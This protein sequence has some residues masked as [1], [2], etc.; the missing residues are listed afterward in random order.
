MEMDTVGPKTEKPS[1][2]PTIAICEA[3]DFIVI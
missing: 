2:S 3:E 1:E